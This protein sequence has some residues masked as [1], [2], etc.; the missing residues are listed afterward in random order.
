MSSS[1]LLSTAPAATLEGGLDALALPSS[2][3]RGFLLR[4]EDTSAGTAAGDGASS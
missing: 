2:D 4:E 3:R 1:S